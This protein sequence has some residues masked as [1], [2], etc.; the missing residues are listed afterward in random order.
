MPGYL[1]LTVIGDDRPGLVESLAETIAEHDG[2]WLESRM[3]HLAGK[4]AGVLRVSVPQG[5]ALELRE[6][7]TGLEANGLHIFAQDGE[8]VRDR[9][10]EVRLSLVSSDRPGIVREV[11]T[12]LSRHR[13]NV[14]E[15]TTECVAAPM[16][17]ESL[18]KADARLELPDAL[19]AQDLLRDIEAVAHDMMVEVEELGGDGENQAS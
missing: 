5:Q 7:L 13:V 9:L 10:R 17:G 4:F 1:V 12:V 18:F 19:A 2:S 14:E 15:L 6:A 8:S 11:S 16:S 3:S